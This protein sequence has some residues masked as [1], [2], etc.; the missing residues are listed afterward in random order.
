[1]LTEVSDTLSQPQFDPA[2]ET[3]RHVRTIVNVLA[4]GRLT[5]LGR[6]TRKQK[7]KVARPRPLLGEPCL[8][9]LSQLSPVPQFLPPPP[10]LVL[11]LS[12]CLSC[13]PAH[14][15]SV[16]CR[17]IIHF[18]PTFSFPYRTLPIP[19]H[20]IFHPTTTLP[21]TPPHI[22]SIKGHF[23]LSSP[24]DPLSDQSRLR[25]PRPL[26]RLLGPS[27][28]PPPPFSTT[29]TVTA[30]S[31]ARTSHNSHLD[32]TLPPPTTLCVPTTTPG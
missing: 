7:T 19:Q 25:P 6:G 18:S 15:A 3:H 28:P 16:L 11:C 13:P 20:L 30:A 4:G 23:P 29:R 31:L 8:V 27:L 26:D 5:D 14:P 2:V 24:A 17:L 21:R 1:M 12:P 22:T 32:H 9:A 10:P